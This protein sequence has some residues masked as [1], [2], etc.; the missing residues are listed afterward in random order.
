MRLYPMTYFIADR[1]Y[2]E[3]ISTIRAG[4]IGLPPGLLNLLI[5]TIQK[6][7]NIRS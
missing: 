5:Y 2:A 1:K 6:D 7:D 3:K 4:N